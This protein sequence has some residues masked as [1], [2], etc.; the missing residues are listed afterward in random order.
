MKWLTSQPASLFGLGIPPAPYEALAGDERMDGVLKTRL[1]KLA[2]DFDLKDNY[3]AVQ[4]FGRGYAGGEGPLPPSLQAAN[5][6]AV[7]GRAG[8]GDVGHV[9]FTD[10]MAVPEAETGR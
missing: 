9:N 3:F 8:R 5:H 2:C 4:A 10:F 7:V 6:A 1:E